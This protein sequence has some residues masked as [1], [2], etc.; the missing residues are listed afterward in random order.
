MPD[1]PCRRHPR[2]AAPRRAGHRRRAEHPPPRA[3]TP[4]ARSRGRSPGG[5]TQSQRRPLRCARWEPKPHEAP[6]QVEP[7]AVRAR[8]RVTAG[9]EL[10]SE[11]EEGAQR[12]GP[13]PAGPQVGVAE[14]AVQQP[15]IPTLTP[16][17]SSRRIGEVGESLLVAQHPAGRARNVAPRPAPNLRRRGKGTPAPLLDQPVAARRPSRSGIPAPA[18][19]AGE[20]YPKPAARSP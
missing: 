10:C 9:D 4:A 2:T 14:D 6:P 15:R 12:F 17:G 19:C 16:Q 11:L 3:A 13:V 8:Q 5:H 7:V 1:L 20:G 18:R